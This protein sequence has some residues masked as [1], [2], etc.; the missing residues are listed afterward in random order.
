MFDIKVYRT[1]R[2]VECMAQTGMCCID[3]FVLKPGAGLDIN[4]KKW[5]QV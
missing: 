2:T 5:A 1:L 3:W 4:N